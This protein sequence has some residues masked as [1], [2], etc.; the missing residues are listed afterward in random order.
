[1]SQLEKAQSSVNFK[2][3]K[4]TF[5]IKNI[6]SYLLEKQKLHLVIYNKELQKIYLIDIED[7]KEIS[8]KYIIGEK[9]GKGRE[10]K[11]LDNILLFEGEYL[12]GKRNGKGKEYYY[13]YPENTENTLKFE[14]EYLNGKRN[15]KGKEYNE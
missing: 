3:I 8:G 7:Y 12:N 13:R 6:F 5:I 14:G 4:S 15:G 9:N 1:M 11:L 10:Y 2:E